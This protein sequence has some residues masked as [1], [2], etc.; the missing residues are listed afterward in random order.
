MVLPHR[1]AAPSV[2]HL[3]VRRRHCSKCIG[4]GAGDKISPTHTKGEEIIRNIS[5]AVQK[6]YVHPSAWLAVF[7]VFTYAP[8]IIDIAPDKPCLRLL[9][10]E[11]RKLP[12]LLF[13]CQT[14]N[15]LDISPMGIGVTSTSLQNLHRHIILAQRIVQRSFFIR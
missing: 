15:H 13:K 12:F 11:V 14:V 8:S 7:Y 3:P 1:V 10:K 4:H 6:S 2:A 5:S 9:K